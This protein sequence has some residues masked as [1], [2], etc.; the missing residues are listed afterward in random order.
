MDGPKDFNG[1]YTGDELIFGKNL[2]NKYLISNIKNK[3]L[4]QAPIFIFLS[5]VL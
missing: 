4:D 1:Y 5:Y 3:W 2:E